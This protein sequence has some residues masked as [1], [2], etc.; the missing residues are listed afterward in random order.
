[1]TL[2]VNP[3]PL[4]SKEPVLSTVPQPLSNATVAAFFNADLYGDNIV[5]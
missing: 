4:V 2:D 1:M 3:G 5:G